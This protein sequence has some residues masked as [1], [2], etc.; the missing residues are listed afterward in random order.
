MRAY[1]DFMAG[2]SVR[3][4]V[5]ESRRRAARPF[6]D[7]T[8]SR[9]RLRRA[10]LRRDVRVIVVTGPAGVG[11][12]ELV[13]RVLRTLPWL[14]VVRDSLEA[15]PDVRRPV[16]VVDP[17]DGRLT[18]SAMRALLDGS[19]ARIVL[20]TAARPPI[21]GATV[22]EVDG[23]P[24]AYFK[25]FA[26]RGGGPFSGLDHRT[27]ERMCGYF[28]GVPRL[29]QV[30]DGV[31]TTTNLTA[32]ELADRVHEWMRQP[33]EWTHLRDRLLAELPPD[34]L[35]AH[36]ALAALGVPV[37]PRDVAAMV[38]PV[39]LGSPVFH[40]VAGL[41]S[42]P[43]D[44][45]GEED[46]EL[47]V[48]VAEVLRE[49]RGRQVAGTAQALAEVGAWLRAGQPLRALLTIEDLDSGPHPDEA[50][51]AARERLA[52]DVEPEYQVTNF[53]VLGRLHHARDDFDAAWEC[54]SRALHLVGGGDPVR[55]EIR[56]DLARLAL[57]R[58]DTGE[59][60]LGFE[61]VRDDPYAAPAVVAAA[62]SALKDIAG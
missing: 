22:V 18:E 62:V 34:Q 7:R 16:I 45:A 6:L 56:L 15:G 54:Y 26:R 36:R 61:Q 32:V 17:A 43:E 21:D 37:E 1:R 58:G 23:L 60:V 2:L 29:V 28:H 9:S 27:Q 5:G 49:R 33:L 53:H 20:V 50:F 40:E 11:K 8:E 59:A 25:D 46:P 14:T 3:G 52:G 13:T 12:S 48:R 10:L 39:D 42:V 41:Y 24:L 55:A 38:G 19:R 47:A 30:F 31:V 35:A 57:D 51:R 44:D 4:W